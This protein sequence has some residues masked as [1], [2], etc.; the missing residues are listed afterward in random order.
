MLYGQYFY[1]GVGNFPPPRYL[2]RF[3]LMRVMRNKTNDNEI[4]LE[5]IRSF[6]E[7][8]GRNYSVESIKQLMDLV[9]EMMR[10][11]SGEFKCKSCGG[12]YRIYAIKSEK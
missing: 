1:G 12:K 2:G 6:L 3:V 5:A 7:K 8:Q 10:I 4:S 11:A 9:E